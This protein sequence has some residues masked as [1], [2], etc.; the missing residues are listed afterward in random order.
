MHIKDEGLFPHTDFG[1]GKF[2]L[3][4]SKY[5]KIRMLKDNNIDLIICRANLGEGLTKELLSKGECKVDTQ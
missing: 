1:G 5:S 4:L 3:Y 2:M